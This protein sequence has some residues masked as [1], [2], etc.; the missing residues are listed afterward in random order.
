MTA[1]T[2]PYAPPAV[3]EPAAERRDSAWHVEAGCIHVQDGAVLP[4]ID[5]ETGG[6]NP[7][8]KPVE[9]KF[10]KAHWSMGSVGLGPLL[11]LILP[12]HL[13]KWD[14]IPVGISMTVIAMVWLS[15]YLVIFLALSHRMT[16]TTYAHPVEEAR[17]KRNKNIRGTLYPL[18]LVLLISSIYLLFKDTTA[19][20]STALTCMI[21]L[22]VI[23]MIAISL[24]QYK[25][26]PTL[27]MTL[28]SDGWLKLAGIHPDALRHLEDGRVTH[29]QTP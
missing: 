16:F 14:A 17:R 29:P 15:V 6:T 19:F 27:I 7:A 3:D 1:R 20:Q 12:R 2:D 8:L 22:S 26:R 9:R 4:A 25:E 18:S 5:L 11:F 23:G 24:W 28:G 13:K 21:V 10:V